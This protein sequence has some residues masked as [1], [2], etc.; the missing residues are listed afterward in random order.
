MVKKEGSNLEKYLF[1]GF[2]IVI[3]A[4]ILVNKGIEGSRIKTNI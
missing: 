4:V 3:L 2:I 1:F